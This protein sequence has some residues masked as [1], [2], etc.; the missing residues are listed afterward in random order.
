MENFIEISV[1]IATH[2]RSDLLV[3]LL[4]SLEK[5]NY[6][7]AK[8]EVIVACDGCT[9]NTIL[10]L[11]E[12]QTNMLNLKWLDLP[13]G[14]PAKARNAGLQHAR[15]KVVAFTDDDCLASE[16][17]LSVINQTL[18]NTN[19]IGIQGKTITDKKKV[20]PL[21]HQI[22]NLS[23]HAAVPTCNA[24]FLKDVLLKVGAFD[25]EF[26]FAHNEDADLAWRMRMEGNIIFAPEMLIH[27]PPR[28]VT[29]KKTLSRMKILESEFML[30]HKNPGL[31]R[32][33]RNE[34][35]W[36]T[37][38]SEVFIKHQTLIFKSRLKYLNKP[39]LMIK[40]MSISIY[41]WMDLLVK[42]PKFLKADKYYKEKYSKRNM[43]NTNKMAA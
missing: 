28:K 39:L 33:W 12:V 35:P 5:Q 27:H 8:Y 10:K 20:S 24:A 17:W 37:I 13:K 25:E 21:T 30:Y 14:N 2:N 43:T 29:F 1:V 3:E 9:D 42:Y 19:V 22:E 32:F 36:Q 26:P 15:G 31:Y 38:Y 18:K 6:N 34:S 16:N 4:N 11:K 40:G 7:S 41:W 23:G